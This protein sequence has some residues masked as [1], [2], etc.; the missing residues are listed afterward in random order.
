MEKLDG[1]RRCDSYNDAVTPCGLEAS[2]DWYKRGGAQPRRSQK[3]EGWLEQVHVAVRSD[4]ESRIR[5]KAICI[6][7][8]LNMRI[9]VVGLT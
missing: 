7:L 6:I 1:E 8:A 5:M 2:R 4:P 9:I 3:R